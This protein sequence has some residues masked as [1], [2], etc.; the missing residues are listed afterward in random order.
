MSEL[1]LKIEKSKNGVL[2]KP[3]KKGKGR[4]DGVELAK[5]G[6]ASATV[7]PRDGAVAVRQRGKPPPKGICPPCFEKM[8]L[9]RDAKVAA[10]R[11]APHKR[12][13]AHLLR[14][15]HPNGFYVLRDLAKACPQLTY[16]AVS[17]YLRQ[18]LLLDGLVVRVPAPQG[19]AHRAALRNGAKHSD[20]IRWLYRLTDAGVAEREAILARDRE[21]G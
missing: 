8:R 16:D 13:R 18:R 4:T 12:P 15:M 14:A 7:R 10:I 5:M 6:L 21:G 11:A 20:P 17:V 1:D 2:A 9:A 19:M 3:L